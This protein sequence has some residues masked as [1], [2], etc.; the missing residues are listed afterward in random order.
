MIPSFISFDMRNGSL[1]IFCY[2]YILFSHQDSFWFGIGN[3]KIGCFLSSSSANALKVI[4]GFLSFQILKINMKFFREKKISS[5][6]NVLK[7]NAKLLVESPKNY[8]ME[9][10]FSH[11]FELFCLFKDTMF[12]EE[13]NPQPNW[14]HLGFFCLYSSCSAIKQWD[15]LFVGNC[16]Y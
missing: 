2:T 15:F 11:R 5:G 14:N 10:V 9:F 7:R 3:S 16:R 6:T 1:F 13:R 8:F 4:I 12:W